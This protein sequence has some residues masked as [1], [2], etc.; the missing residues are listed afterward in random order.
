MIILWIFTFLRNKVVFFTQCYIKKIFLLFILSCFSSYGNQDDGCEELIN[1][2]VSTG[3]EPVYTGNKNDY[4]AREFF[5]LRMEARRGN[6]QALRELGFMYLKGAGVR[7]NYT[8]AH[9]LLERAAELGSGVAKSDLAGIYFL[10]EGVKQDYEQAFYWASRS[11]QVSVSAYI[12]GAV[13]FDGLVVQRDY[14]QAFYWLKKAVELDAELINRLDFGMLGFMYLEGLGV[15]QDYEQAFYWAQ[16]SFKQGSGISAHIIGFLYLEGLGVK[17][18]Y[19]QAFDWL[20][21]AV[22]LGDISAFD[23]VASMYREGRGVTQDDEQALHWLEQGAQKGDKNSQHNLG[24]THYK[25]EDYK[26]SFYWYE[27]S[28]QQGHI[29]ARYPVGMMYANGKGVAKDNIQAYKWLILYRDTD[30]DTLNTEHSD[31]PDTVLVG[32]SESAKEQLSEL[33]SEMTADQNTI[34]S[35]TG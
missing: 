28:A 2:F 32:Y 27:K 24:V 4:S 11:T 7:Q 21:K 3:G 15:K 19:G 5:V 17:Q 29:L 35:Y 14:E 13:H 8:K 20:K 34:S 22:E 12:V 30:S 6:P 26:K 33:E 9:R 16:Q 31:V 18:D 10:G 1:K 25:E 23:L